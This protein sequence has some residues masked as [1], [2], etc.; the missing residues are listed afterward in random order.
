MAAEQISTSDYSN[1]LLFID[2]KWTPATGGKTLPVENPATGAQIATLAHATREDLDRALAAADRGF[3]IWRKVSAYERAKIMRKAANILRER[4]EPV[5][6]NLTIEQGKPLA[7]ARLEINA[8]ADV[9][10]WFA[11][12]AQRL[13]GRLIASRVEGVVQTVVVEPVGPVAAFAP[14]NFPMNQMVR[15]LSAAIA[16]GC[17]IICKGPEETPATPAALVQAFADAG[18]P[19]G[20]VNLVFGN[21]AEISSYLIPHPVIRKVTFTGSTPVG[22]QLAAIAGQHMKRVTMELGGHAPAIVCEDADLDV[23]TK[24]LAFGKFRNAGQVCVAPSRFLVHEKVYDTF[25]EKFAAVARSQKVGSG[26]DDTTTMG[27][28]ANPRRVKAM[29]EMVQDAV[30]KG[31]KLVTGGQRIGT[32][33]NYFEPTVLKDVPTNAKAMNEEPFGPLALM[34]PFNALEEAL[35]EANR[36]PYGL[37]AYGYSRSMQTVDKISQGIES[38]MISFNNGALAL[39]ET[40]FGGVKDSGYG[41][42]GGSEAVEAYINRKFITR[43]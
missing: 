4:V 18:L 30:A 10:D 19:P 35:A 14:W 41:S 2:G 33:G 16:A 25:V 7:Q 42:E 29:E 26:L 36:L 9:I 5:A 1:T 12:E 23:A 15:K 28:L 20:V 13:Y 22:K 43:D 37:A 8:G 32:T 31:A 40:P 21:P 6:R 27:P 17:S 11:G 3:K 39:I 34:V 38:G 24:M